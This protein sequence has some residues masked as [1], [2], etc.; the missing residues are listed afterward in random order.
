MGT[1][2]GMYTLLSEHSRSAIMTSLHV[3]NIVVADLPFLNKYK[4]GNNNG[5]CY[6]Y[7]LGMCARG[8]GPVMSDGHTG[9]EEEIL[10][11]FAKEVV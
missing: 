11:G 9:D 2:T 1:G 5:M 8:D 7:A 6:P 4:M 10:K 3:V